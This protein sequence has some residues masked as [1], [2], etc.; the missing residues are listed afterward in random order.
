[1]KDRNPYMVTFALL[2]LIYLGL[3]GWSALIPSLGC[4]VLNS[5]GLG[6]CG[7]GWKLSRELI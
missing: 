6:W 2:G 4:V 1:M 7:L 5:F 3:L